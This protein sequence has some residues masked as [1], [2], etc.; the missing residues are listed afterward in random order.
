MHQILADECIH[1]D[2]IEALVKAGFSLLAAEK[3]NLEGVSDDSVFNFAVKTR[4]VLLTFDR[5]FGNFFRFNI[6]KSAGIVIVLIAEMQKG[7][8]IKNTLNFFKRKV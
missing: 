4:R 6:K 7:E 3:A 5:E 1:R 8:I 2:L